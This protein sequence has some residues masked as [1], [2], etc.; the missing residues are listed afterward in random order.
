ME[1][2]VDGLSRSPYSTFIHL[3]I[4]SLNSSIHPFIQPTCARVVSAISLRASCIG[5]HD[6]VKDGEEN[7]CRMG[8]LNEGG[9]E[10]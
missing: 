4:H 1:E 9:M 5:R 2:W 6:G 3:I 10:K 7:K 8:K